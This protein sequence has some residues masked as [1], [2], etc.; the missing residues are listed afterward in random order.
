MSNVKISVIV[1]AKNEASRIETCLKTIHENNPDELIVV[2]GN[3]SDNTVEIA[4]KYATRVIVS[5]SGSLSKDRQRGIDEAKN[6]FVALFDADHRLQKNDVHSLYEDLIHFDFDIV[7]SQVR[8][9]KNL[10]FWD[11]AED[12]AWSIVHNNPGRRDMIGTAP[13][14]YK[15][16]V[17]EYEKFD[18]HITKTID[19]TDFIHRLS[20]HPEIKF[21]IGNTMVAQE[22]FS[23]FSVYVKKFLWYGKGDGEFCR[24][25]PHRTFSMVFHLLI[26]YPILHSMKGLA[27]FKIKSI[28]FFWLQGLVR[29]YSLL[30][31]FLKPT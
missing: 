5:E 7:Q 18:D 30:R 22:H 27:R 8:S 11:A 13:A 29:L 24:K 6:D 15:K 14:I 1:C 9:Y 12:Q 21:G 4:K 19:D 3:S 26:R 25:F 23:D 17:F 16:K 20:K 28:P 10:G 31:Y 2:D